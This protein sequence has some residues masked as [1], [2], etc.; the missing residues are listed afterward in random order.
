VAGK[1]A[2]YTWKYVPF[3]AAAPLDEKKFRSK[4][5][6]YS[7]INGERELIREGVSRV[8]RVTVYEWDRDAGRWM[9]FERLDLK[10]EIDA[11]RAAQAPKDEK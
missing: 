7:G 2:T 6:C 8:I 10:K 3:T 1:R 9:T 5:T 11:E 4:P